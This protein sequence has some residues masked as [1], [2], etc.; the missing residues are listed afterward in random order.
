MYSYLCRFL[1]FLLF[2]LLSLSFSFFF[3]SFFFFFLRHFVCRMKFFAFV[4]SFFFFFFFLSF[5]FSAHV[6]LLF[7]LFPF[8]FSLVAGPCGI[9]FFFLLLRPF[10]CQLLNSL[11]LRSF[12]I[13]FIR[14]SFLLVN[15]T[16]VTIP[17]SPPP[18]LHTSSNHSL[19]GRPVIN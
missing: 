7:F 17:P 3:L 18:T 6:Y 10:V 12:P 1:S 14:F 16:S 8:L 11:V 19:L 13:F 4:L 2:F 15:G 5:S 9:F